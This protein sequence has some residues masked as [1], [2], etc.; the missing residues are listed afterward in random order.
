MKIYLCLIMNNTETVWSLS[1]VGVRN[2][3]SRF[4]S[5]RGPK[6]IDLWCTRCPVKG[7]AG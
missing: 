1:A 4:S 7:M 2:L 3:S 6:S 5:T